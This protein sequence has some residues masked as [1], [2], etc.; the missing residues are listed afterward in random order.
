MA[1]AGYLLNNFDNVYLATRKAEGCFT[2]DGKRAPIIIFEKK[3]DGSHIIVEAVTDTKMSGNYIVTEYLAKNG[4]DMTEVTKGLRSPM[5][6]ASDPE[7][8]VRNIVADPS[9]TAE[10]LQSPMDAAS[11]PR[12]TSETLADLPS[13]DTTVPQQDGQ[14]N[15][16]KAGGKC[17]K[18]TGFCGR[19]TARNAC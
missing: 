19:G 16:E 6:A 10:E 18:P 5:S 4:V 3:I 17:G 12:D 1:R 13:A 8:H 14:V 9:A 7:A 11:D 15:V 2:N